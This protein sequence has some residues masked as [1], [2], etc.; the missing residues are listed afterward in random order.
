MSIHFGRAG[1]ALAF[2]MLLASPQFSPAGYLSIPTDYTVA[3]GQTVT[4]AVDLIAESAEVSFLSVDIAIGYDT[5]VFTVSNARAG[6][7]TGGGSG[8]N[9]TFNLQVP[10]EISTTQSGSSPL[11]LASNT[12]ASVLLFD[13][14]ALTTA[15]KGPSPINIL[16]QGSNLTTALDEGTVMLNPAPTNGADDPRIDGLVT[17]SAVP[18]PTSIVLLGVGGVFLLMAARKVRPERCLSRGD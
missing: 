9:G 2:L 16:A 17:I 7:L 5:N 15:P 12:T 3:P 13:L 4:V 14:T 11:T 6:T 8:F 1:G 10:G 18:E